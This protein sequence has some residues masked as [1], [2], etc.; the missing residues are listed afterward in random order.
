[1]FEDEKGDSKCFSN[2]SRLTV[3]KYAELDYAKLYWYTR[4]VLFQEL[5]GC[6][7][8]MLAINFEHHLLVK[9][10]AHMIVLLKFKVYTVSRKNKGHPF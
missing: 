8:S 2:S 1:M 10:L 6:F 9:I 4:Q 5:D 7:I 3:R